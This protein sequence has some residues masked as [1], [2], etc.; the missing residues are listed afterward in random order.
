[1]PNTKAV[2]I[3][4]TIPAWLKKKMD[5]HRKTKRTNWSRIAA[6]AFHR[7]LKEYENEQKDISF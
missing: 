1:M 4:L 5:S 6:R 2:H 3:T 7:H